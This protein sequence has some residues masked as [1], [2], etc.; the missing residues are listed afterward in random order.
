[1]MKKF[2]ALLFF[3]LLTFSLLPISA[4][5]G[6]DSGNEREDLVEVV[7]DGVISG[8]VCDAT[9]T[10]YKYKSAEPIDDEY[11]RM[12]GTFRLVMTDAAGNVLLDEGFDT[13]S[14]SISLT[15]PGD[16]YCS[17]YSSRG[18]LQGLSDGSGGYTPF[19]QHF[20]VT[21]PYEPSVYEE[22]TGAFVT[23]CM[24]YPD[25]HD[26]AFRE[27][28]AIVHSIASGVENFSLTDCADYMANAMAAYP[29]AEYASLYDEF[30]ANEVYA[31]M[32]VTPLGD[33]DP[34]IL[35]GEDPYA[36][37]S[38]ECWNYLVN[39]QEFLI[40]EDGTICS[41]AEYLAFSDS[42]IETPVDETSL[43]ESTP[44]QNSGS[45]LPLIAGGVAVAGVCI[46]A[47]VI[48]TRKKNVKKS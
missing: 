42:F 31:V 21:E 12:W 22:M 25:D 18:D 38:G 36:F 30:R 15:E 3:L 32:E 43:D 11:H 34:I 29:E 17:V 44:S 40:N 19:T 9:V 28:L 46:G 45:S 14:K 16:Y 4:H 1:M 13:P 23:C 8:P 6:N 7:W 24:E 5:A 47:A 2:F 48:R 26:K 33:H 37:W 10:L 41:Y 35:T 39:G 27:Y 20:C